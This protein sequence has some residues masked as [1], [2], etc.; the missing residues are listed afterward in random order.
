MNGSYSR[1]GA[2]FR[3]D[4]LSGRGATVIILP[5]CNS[6]ASL[7]RG[8]L[9][10]II[11]WS[12]LSSSRANIGRLVILSI[13]SAFFLAA[14]VLVKPLL[15][16]LLCYLIGLYYFGFSTFLGSYLGIWLSF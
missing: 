4:A 10:P 6:P 1:G 16:V 15:D 14:L 11:I 13:L 5:P 9:G 12:L 8:V 2:A 7:P 3:G